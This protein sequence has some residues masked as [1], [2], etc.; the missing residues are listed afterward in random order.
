[1]RFFI[2]PDSGTTSGSTL[3]A[4]QEPPGR[5]G[6]S[7]SSQASPRTIRPTRL[8]TA[9]QRVAATAGGG[10]VAAVKAVREEGR[11][12]GGGRGRG[13]AAKTGWHDTGHESPAAV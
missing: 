11:R 2:R 3:R 7:H 1:M 5:S 12:A 8:P 9:S 6:A 13:G 10:V 4:S